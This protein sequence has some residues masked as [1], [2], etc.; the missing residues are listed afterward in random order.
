VTSSLAVSEA[1]MRVKSTYRNHVWKPE[2][3][4]LWKY[5]IFFLHKSPSKIS[6]RHTIHSL[7]QRADARESADNDIIYRIWR[8]SP[9]CGSRI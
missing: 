5:K 8:I 4:K 3:E 7:L 2:K 6:F 1:A 9:V